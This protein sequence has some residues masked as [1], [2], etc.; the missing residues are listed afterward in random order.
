[1]T[2][3]F[4]APDASNVIPMPAKLVPVDAEFSDYGRDPRFLPGWFILPSVL[5]GAAVVIGAALALA[6]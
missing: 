6:W 3:A 4:D 2:H 5:A 1:M